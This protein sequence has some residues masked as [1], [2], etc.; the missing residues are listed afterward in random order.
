MTRTPPSDD[1]VARLPPLPANKGHLLCSGW[2][3]SLPILASD[4]G[5]PMDGGDT[6]ASPPCVRDDSGFLMALSATGSRM[7]PPHL[8]VV[9]EGTPVVPGRLQE[10]WYAGGSYSFSEDKDSQP[11]LDLPEVL[12]ATRATASKPNMAAALAPNNLDAVLAA[13]L[14]SEHRC[15]RK[16]NSNMTALHGRNLQVELNLSDVCGDIA[17]IRGDTQRLTSKSAALVELNKATHLA[18]ESNVSNFLQA[19]EA[20][21]AQNRQSLEAH[22]ASFQ[23]YVEEANKNIASITE[24][25]TQFMADMQTKLQSLFDWMKYLKKTFK[26]IPVPVTNHL[27]KTV[28]QVIALVVDRTLPTTLASA[29]KNTISPTLKTVMDDTITNSITLLLEGS[30]MNFTAK[31]SLISTDMAQAVRD[32]VASAEAPLLECYSAVQEDYSACKA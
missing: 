8:A 25:H 15:N 24:T 21:V 30:F 5:D 31:I 29:L 4:N 14:E 28:P 2:R 32:L 18:V 22:M 17:L 10:N 19:M 7:T 3:T 13:D 9:I 11:L 26:D 23:L 16:F 6:V 27:N 1:P 12:E 20:N